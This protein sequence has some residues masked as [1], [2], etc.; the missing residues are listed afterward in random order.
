MALFTCP[1]ARGISGRFK[2]VLERFIDGARPRLH[3]LFFPGSGH[4]IV[5]GLD[6]SGAGE[7]QKGDVPEI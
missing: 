5:C 7:G 3:P 4:V 1:K 6:P 2:S